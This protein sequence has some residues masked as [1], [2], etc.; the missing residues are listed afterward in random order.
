[1]QDKTEMSGFLLMCAEIRGV[2]SFLT[3]EIWKMY[4]VQYARVY[5]ITSKI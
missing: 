2:K 4:N 1:M 3:E 5:Y